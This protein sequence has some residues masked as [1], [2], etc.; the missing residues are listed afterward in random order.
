MAF[1][2]RERFDSVEPRFLSDSSGRREIHYYINSIQCP[3]VY[4][5]DRDAQQAARYRL[6]IKDLE[7]VESALSL[8]I[9]QY[10][11][12]ILNQ[13]DYLSSDTEAVIN[14]SV[15][16]QET[17]ILRSIYIASVVSY[18]KT[19]TE[20][21]GRRLKLEAKNVF[22][23]IRDRKIHQKI[24]EDRH[25]YLAHAGYSESE[26]STVAVILSPTN[27]LRILEGPIVHATFLQFPDVEDMTDFYSI[28]LKL[29]EYC[30]KNER[31]KLDQVWKKVNDMSIDQ[32]YEMAS[33]KG[34]K[35]VPI[36]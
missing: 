30:E 25:T 35:L 5:K 16:D 28:V 21:R 14:R 12:D 17:L 3:T 24:I 23:E 34:D 33:L 11:S 29:K 20:A 27:P 4:L 31:L 2:S 9:K 6:I 15:T 10:P 7:Y 36:R 13:C 26:A 18:A 19:F 22:S 8:A 32:L 1:N